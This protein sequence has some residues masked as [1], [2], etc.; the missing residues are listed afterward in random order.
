MKSQK[1]LEKK[2]TYTKNFK[3]YLIINFRKFYNNLLNFVTPI[4]TNQSPEGNSFNK[5]QNDFNDELMECDDNLDNNKFLCYSW[6]TLKSATEFYIFFINQLI[7]K[8]DNKVNY[9][10]LFKVNNN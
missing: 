9:Y 5:F 6:R 8:Y 1:F 2:I 7:L 4:L 10:F 3:K